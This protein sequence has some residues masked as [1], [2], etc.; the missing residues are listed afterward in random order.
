[1]A[2][3][4]CVLLVACGDDRLS[5]GDFIAQADEI[6]AAAE[7]RAQELPQ[8][9]DPTEAETYASGLEE[10][11]EGYIADLRE[12]QPPEDD[13]EQ[14]DGLIEKIEQAGLNIVEAIRTQ[15]GSGN[16]ADAY[17]E[18]LHLAEEAN[19]EAEAYGFESCGRSEILEHQD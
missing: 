19:E 3:F 17:S 8:P 16:P 15:S 5:K 4:A 14:L 1:M 18:A 11:T 7:T 2:G 10:I 9:A 13:V 6:C 12:L